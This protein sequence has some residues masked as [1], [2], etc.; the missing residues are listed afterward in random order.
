MADPNPRDSEQEPRSDMETT[1]PDASSPEH[2]R[3]YQAFM[4][5]ITWSTAGIA[6]VLILLA[7]FL[8]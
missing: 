4:R 8:L 1:P 2:R 3:T 5:L 7:L 6:L